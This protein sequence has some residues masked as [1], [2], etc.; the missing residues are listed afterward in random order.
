MFAGQNTALM[1]H[2]ASHGYIVYSIQHSLDSADVVLPDGEVIS[3]QQETYDSLAALYDPTDTSMGA[4]LPETYSGRYAAT[5]ETQKLYRSPELRLPGK[6]APVWLADRLFL[7]DALESGQIPSAITD[8]AAKSQFS[9]VGQMGMSFG[10]STTGGLCMIDKRCVAAINLDGGDYHG[11]PFGGNIPV[12]FLMLYSDYEAMYKAMG[13]EGTIEQGYNDFSYE[14]LEVAGLRGDVYRARILNS[15][16]MGMSDLPLA[17]RQPLSSFLF[18]SID[19]REMIDVVNASVLAF[20][21]HHLLEVPNDFPS[22][23]YQQYQDQLIPQGLAPIREW[24]VSENPEDQATLVQLEADMGPMLISLY[25][26]KE[27]EAVEAFLLAFENGDNDMPESGISIDLAHSKGAVLP[28]REV[29]LYARTD[30]GDQTEFFLGLSGALEGRDDL[31]MFGRV[32]SGFY[33]IP[34]L[35]GSGEPLKNINIV[36]AKILTR[37]A[38]SEAEDESN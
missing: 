37:S 11:T 29:S 14:R 7:L 12:P 5:V 9:A 6:S 23:L 13:Y 22:K 33:E 15:S 24:W 10:G 36:S 2:L 17:V 25:S 38:A 1:M 8:V 32:L 34:T 20:F 16:H 4:Q 30:P 18:G 31:K 21:D 19:G 3:T 27:P 26:E 28:T 35:P